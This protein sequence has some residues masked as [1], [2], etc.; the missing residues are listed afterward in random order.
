MSTLE[1]NKLV[2]LAD[3]GTIT[4]GDSGD[5]FDIPSGATLDVTGATVSGLTTGKIVQV[6]QGQSATQISTS[7]TDNDQ[8]IVTQSITPT[9]SSSKILVIG[10]VMG[11]QGGTSSVNTRWNLSLIHI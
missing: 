6:L 4:L 9:A 10:T 7:I 1:V 8:D 5:T 2:P 11:I 3:N